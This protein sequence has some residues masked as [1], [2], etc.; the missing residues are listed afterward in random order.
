MVMRPS[1]PD[2]GTARRT[3]R[4]VTMGV[5]GATAPAMLHA[6]AASPLIEE[7]TRPAA[8]Q[9]PVVEEDPFLLPELPEAVPADHTPPGTQAGTPSATGSAASVS[10]DQEPVIPDDPDP[11][12]TGVKSH[13]SP[14]QTASAPARPTQAV[15]EPATQG[16]GTFDSGT[17]RRIAERLVSLNLLAHAD[18]AQDSALL[19][20]AIRTFQSN[21]G[22][23]PTGTLDRD[24]VGRLL[25]TQ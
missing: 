15:P 20:E 8:S 22:I 25:S 24:T 17:M 1:H 4:M 5:L 3:L 10:F 19:A 2:I 18:D 23:A 6:Q 14:T 12:P 11:K 13:A 21:S 16:N 7:A 9:P